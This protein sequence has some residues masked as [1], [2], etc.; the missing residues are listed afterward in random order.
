MKELNGNSKPKTIDTL[1]IYSDSFKGV[2][3]KIKNRITN[4]LEK[5]I[6]N[7]FNF[8]KKIETK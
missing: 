8:I 2:Y 5:T 3:P 7:F 1:N 6:A 4:N